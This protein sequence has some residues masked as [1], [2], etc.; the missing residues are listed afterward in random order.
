MTARLKKSYE[1]KRY[2][3]VRRFGEVCVDLFRALGLI[4]LA[5][6]LCCAFIYV[7]CLLLSA[8]Y[9]SI[10]ETDVRG[11]KELTQKDI[12]TLAE[13]KPAQNLLAINKKAI[14]KRVAENPWVKNIYVGR[15]LPDRL[16]LELRERQPLTL[17]QIKNDFYLV[18]TE[19]DVFKKVNEGDETDLPVIT[20]L[21]A[22]GKTKEPYFS[23]ALKLV[24]TLQNTRK[25]GYLGSV[26]EVNIN[27][28]FGL[29]VLTE[30]GFYLRLGTDGLESK[31]GKVK[32]VMADL[33]KKGMLKGLIC[34]DLT[35][36]SKITVQRKGAFVRNQTE[37]KG[38]G[39]RI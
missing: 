34:F 12:L 2:R 10:K 14:A 8:T 26:S 25:Y 29:S 3:L 36:N 35:D 39:Y 30:R 4:L 5:A 32:A 7:Y 6:V 15:E 11:L 33:E 19:G 24:A 21:D 20:G 23:S 31:L 13:V 9:F 18:D 27:E 1:A 16:V 22:V 28:I 38:N 37:T 17:L